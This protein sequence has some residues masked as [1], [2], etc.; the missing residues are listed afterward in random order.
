MYAC[1]H[2]RFANRVTDCECECAIIRVC[3]SDYCERSRCSGKTT[4]TPSHTHTRTHTRPLTHTHT[5]TPLTKPPRHTQA[6]LFDE[7]SDNLAYIPHSSIT[8]MMRRLGVKINPLQVHT[9][10]HAACR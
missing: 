5:F 4:H 1:V 8:L 6:S 10:I 7:L 9:S 3:V 2:T